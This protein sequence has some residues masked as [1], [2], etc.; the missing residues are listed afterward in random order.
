MKL[1]DLPESKMVADRRGKK[2]AETLAEMQEQAANEPQPERGKPD[3]TSDLA[4]ALGVDD[5][6]GNST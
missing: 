3:P 6:G 4:K 5:I 2:P 1:D